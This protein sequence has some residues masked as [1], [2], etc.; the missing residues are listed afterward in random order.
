MADVHKGRHR[1]GGPPR[2]DAAHLAGFTD[3][4]NPQLLK[5]GV[6]L[7][8]AELK[9]MGRAPPGGADRG[10]DPERERNPASVFTAE[11]QQLA[12]ELGIEGDLFAGAGGGPGG[13]EDAGGRRRPGRL[14]PGGAGPGALRVEPVRGLG[15]APPDSRSR[16][17][18][19]SAGSESSSSGGGRD[20]ARKKKSGGRAPPPPPPPPRRGP[21][22]PPPP[23]R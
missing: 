18:R 15:R 10:A 13:T 23:T 3:L 16:K 4:L 11:I 9:V 21:R 14:P 20:R 5:P 7:K 1:A 19:S 8:A 22:R 12:D 2:L 17:S 6:D